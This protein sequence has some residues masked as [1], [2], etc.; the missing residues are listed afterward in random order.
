MQHQKPSFFYSI[1]K[2]PKQTHDIEGGNHLIIQFNKSMR[3]NLL[4]KNP[5]FRGK[6]PIF[7][8]WK[9][10]NSRIQSIGPEFEAIH[11][12]FPIARAPGRQYQ[13][14]AR[15]IRNEKAGDNLGLQRKEREAMEKS[16]EERLEIR[17]GER[18][19]N[20]SEKR[21]AM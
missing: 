17:E 1:K 11:S 10:S 15:W 5:T 9:P 16:W 7:N 2:S 14:L 8:K 3:R 12:L 20:R 6:N 4:K 19:S 18:A 21:R 13:G